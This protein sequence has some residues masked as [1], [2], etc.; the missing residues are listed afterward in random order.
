[1]IAVD[2]TEKACQRRIINDISKEVHWSSVREGTWAK[3]FRDA[4][5]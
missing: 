1:M 3:E 4:Y 2:V 5:L